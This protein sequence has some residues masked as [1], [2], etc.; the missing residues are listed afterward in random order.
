MKYSSQ[1]TIRFSA[2][3][4]PK[5]NEW[6]GPHTHGHR[7]TV[8]VTW[9]REGYPSTDHVVWV[10][11]R[12]KVLDLALEIKDRDLGKMLGATVPNVFG[13]ASFFMERLTINVPVTRV[14]V[15]EDDGPIAII[16]RDTYN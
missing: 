8:T 3:H 5:A 16:E 11:T 13:V 2:G 10:I 12:Q 14:E 6:C 9:E 15:R 4:T 7:Y 1:A